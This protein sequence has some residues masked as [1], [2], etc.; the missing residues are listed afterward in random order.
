MRRK[1]ILFDSIHAD[2]SIFRLYSIG[3]FD[4]T[5]ATLIVTQ[6]ANYNLRLF[7]MAHI[8]VFFCEVLIHCSLSFNCVQQSLH[9]NYFVCLRYLVQLA[10]AVH[11][12]A[13]EWILV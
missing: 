7:F 11:C 1:I 9:L 4:K 6:C 2:E 8:I 12:S 3:Q 13:L 10:S 5:E